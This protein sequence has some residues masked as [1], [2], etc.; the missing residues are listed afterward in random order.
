MGYVRRCSEALLRLGLRDGG[1]VVFAA[2]TTAMGSWQLV[3][4]QPD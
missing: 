4:T 2:I 3:Q 1:A